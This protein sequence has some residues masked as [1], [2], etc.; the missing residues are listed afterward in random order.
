MYQHVDIAVQQVL[1][2]LLLRL[3]EIGTY[4]AV[5]IEA[6]ELEVRSQR[7]AVRRLGSVPG[8]HPRLK[9]LD[10]LPCTE[11]NLVQHAAALLSLIRRGGLH[12]PE[13]DVIIAIACHRL[14]PVCAVHEIDP[15]DVKQMSFDGETLVL[16]LSNGA[17]FQITAINSGRFKRTWVDNT[18]SVPS[19]EAADRIYDEIDVEEAMPATIATYH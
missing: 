1:E 14:E 19:C 13:S 16:T 7:I 12:P 9:R 10:V 5:E 8:D 17:K 6:L 3:D 4:P 11:A 18:D 15:H 2:A